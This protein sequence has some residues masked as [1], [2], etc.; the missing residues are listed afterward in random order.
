ML[1]D[2]SSTVEWGTTP[3]SGLLSVA[4]YCVRS[5]I[6]VVSMEA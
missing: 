3:F 5:G 6:R 2:C 1:L 4:P